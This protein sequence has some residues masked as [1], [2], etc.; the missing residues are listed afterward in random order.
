MFSDEIKTIKNFIW[1]CISTGNFSDAQKLARQI[2]KILS[3]LPKII[4][5]LILPCGRIRRVYLW[6]SLI[7]RMYRSFRLSLWQARRWF[8]KRLIIHVYSICW[9]GE[10][11]L[12]YFLR[13]YSKI[14][15]KIFIYDNMS[16]DNSVAI[17]KS[18]SN[19]KV[20][21]FDSGDEA[22]ED[23][24]LKIRLN[25]WKKSRGLADWVI[26]VD[27]DE[28]LYHKNLVEYLTM[29]KKKGI[30]MPIT[31]GFDM[32]SETLPTSSGMIYDEIKLG[33]F[34]KNYCKSCVFNPNLVYEINYEPGCHWAHPVG[35]IVFDNSGELKLLHYRYIS[36][37]YVLKRYRLYRSR[38]S[39]IN[40]KMGWGRQ[41]DFESEAIKKFNMLKN[42]AVDVVSRDNRRD[43][44]K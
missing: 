40:K 16:N 36:L 25:E 10:I 43:N 42:S 11:L 39:E 19:T 5:I 13:H 14:A 2:K 8:S 27:T 23:I 30:T 3:L 35:R 21:R 15:D 38:K 41:Y 37:D 22:R 24:Q 18:F 34:N 29:C 26:I 44:I 33:V 31:L 28:F 32:V 1:E 7:R 9:N 17:I 4:V 20:I 6:N 12:P